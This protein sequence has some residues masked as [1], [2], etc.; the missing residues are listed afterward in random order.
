MCDHDLMP[1]LAEAR[2]YAA[3]PGRNVVLSDSEQSATRH[4]WSRERKA[5]RYGTAMG[6]Q[7]LAAGWFFLGCQI[8]PATATMPGKPG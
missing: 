4:S 7:P 8:H 3:H 5:G 1:A 6:K 2:P